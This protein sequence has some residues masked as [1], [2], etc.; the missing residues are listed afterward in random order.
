MFEKINRTKT[1]EESVFGRDTCLFWAEND[2]T[3]QNVYV[4]FRGKIRIGEPLIPSFFRIYAKDIYELYLNGHFIGVGPCV[5]APPLLYYDE[6]DMHGKLVKGENIFAIKIHYG[7]HISPNDFQFSGLICEF[8]RTVDGSKQHLMNRPDDWLCGIFQEY[9]VDSPKNV[10]CVGFSE[11]YSL[12]GNEH[13]W[14]SMDFDGTALKPSVPTRSIPASYWRKRPIPYFKIKTRI[15]L[16]IKR[17]D[18]EIIVDFGEMVFGRPRIE[19]RCNFFV[20]ICY[21]EDPSSGWAMSEGRRE[22]Y[23]DILTTS[24]PV[25]F[26][27]QS[28]N[29][30]AFRYLSIS[31]GD[32]DAESIAVDSYDYPLRDIGSFQCSDHGMNHLWEVCDKTLRVCIDDIYNDCPHR[33][34]A[35][36]MD[37]F[38]TSRA[39]L[40]LYGL[41]ALTEKCL[42]QHGIGSL[43]DGKLMSPSIGDGSLLQDYALIYVQFVL[44]HFHVTGDL[45]VLERLFPGV[46]EIMVFFKKFQDTDSLLKDVDKNEGFVYLDNTFELNKKGESAAINAL[47]FGAAKAVSEMARHLGKTSLDAEYG[48]LALRTRIAFIK[49]FNHPSIK[50]CFVDAAPTI[51]KD[52]LNINFSCE[53]GKWAGAGA[54]ARTFVH[55]DLD[56]TINLECAVYAGLVVVCG[57]RRIDL[58]KSPSWAG[59]PIYFPSSFSLFIKKGWNELVFEVESNPLNWDLFIRG[60]NSVLPPLSASCSFD[61]R[62]SFLVEEIEWISKKSL[63]AEKKVS[64]RLWT[65]PVISQSTH[66]YIGF[67]EVNGSL[68]L[69]RAML[70]QVLPENGY[71]RNYL[72]IRV[73]FFCREAKSHLELEKW[74]LPCNTP[75]SAFFFLS[76]LFNCGLGREALEWIRMAWGKMLKMGAVNCWEEW[77]NH[78]SLCHAWGAMPAYFMHHEILGVKHESLWEGAVIIK[79]DLMG[80]EWANGTVAIG[81]DGDES[82]RVSLS[83]DGYRT[84][85]DLEVPSHYEMR[86]DMSMLHNPVVN[87][88]KY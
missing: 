71:T 54:R 59:S 69:N 27:W 18:E 11:H 32:C 24:R 82:V 41:R 51:Q 55:A 81:S 74:I 47:Y 75:W 85:V 86:L 28:F 2:C 19:G 60:A 29:K 77:S 20:K 12:N 46:L 73:P 6:W 8:V 88:K 10:G 65:T 66:G 23:S 9:S 58:P 5:S 48:E 37:S 22:M 84:L 68:D 62:N 13:N 63:E 39:A 35:Q 80:L 56:C 87:L 83:Y 45:A 42:D 43:K 76:S 33:D 26:K 4:Y 78:A 36:W 16:S 15:P 53:L 64:A 50:G 72:S 21:L 31:G 30:R 67:C 49:T 17:V 3:S 79:P 57:D 38:M 34:K 14:H 7:G 44:W 61:D 70:R 40:S 25:S 1:E 52:Y